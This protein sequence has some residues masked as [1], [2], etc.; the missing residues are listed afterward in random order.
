M[1]VPTHGPFCQ[2]LVYRTSCHFCQEGI[3]ILKCTCGSA[4]PLDECG[5]P[6]PKHGCA[7]RSKA[8][9]IG[10]SGFSGLDAAN[11]LLD[12]GIPISADVR[13]KIFPR[14]QNFARNA[15]RGVEITRIK[16]RD[17]KRQSL[18]AVVRELHSSTRRIADVDA[19]SALGRQLLGLHPEA[20][21]RQITLVVN[22]DRPNRSFTALVPDHLVQGLKRGVMVTAEMFGSVRGAFASWVITD[23]D[24]F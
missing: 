23:I 8:G 1:S 7:N 14:S 11:K 22:L 6:W 19:L 13:Q 20:P 4:V 17:G 15:E 3:W 12:L 16:P 5:P 2:T 18:L 9:G 10:G 21:Y 24:P